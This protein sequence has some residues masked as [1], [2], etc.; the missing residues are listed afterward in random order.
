MKATPSGSSGPGSATAAAPPALEGK[1]GSAPPRNPNNRWWVLT[2]IGIGTFMSALD[3][4]VVNT[5][6]PFVRA[7]LHSEVDKIEWVITVYLL[8]VSGLLLG[9]GRWGDMRGHKPVYLTGFVVFLVASALCGLS[10]TAELLIAA[11][12]LQAIGAAMLFASGPAII[13]QNFP[14]E[15]RGTALGVQLTMTYLGLTLGPL[16][17]G[18]LA[19]HHGWASVFYINI[20]VGL[21][22]LYISLRF[23]PADRPPERHKRFDLVGAALF[24]V[25]LVMLLVALN[26]AH[27]WGWLSPTTLGLIALSIAIL[28]FFYWIEGRIQ[29]PMLDLGLIRN[30]L[31][32]FAAVSAVLCYVGLYSTLFLLPYY[33]VEGRG[34]TLTK[35]GWILATQP[36]AMALIAFFSGAL[37]DKLGTRI[38]TTIGMAVLSIGLFLLSRLQPDTPISYVIT[39]LV[40]AGLGTGMFVSPNNSAMLGVAPRERRGIASGIMATARNIGMVLGVGMAGAIFTSVLAHHSGS[41]LDALFAGV[42]SGFLG[43][44]I[45]A[46]LGIVTSFVRER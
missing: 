17:G 22:A 35:T 14:P 8:V 16:F 45:V 28:V 42:R 24:L 25:G 32:S 13:T 3:G 29:D 38:P 34:L 9:M 2:A 1:N 5:I 23:I 43:A 27:E 4:S 10:P 40:L 12:V 21:P 15:M 33:L 39:G 6:Q 31:F 44:C 26:K 36:A 19:Q 46:A 30:R 18:W 37:S 20:P 11:R 41:H 7:A